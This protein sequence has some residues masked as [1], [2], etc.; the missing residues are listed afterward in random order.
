[1]QKYGIYSGIS[2]NDY[3]GNKDYVSS[4]Q[5]KL[6]S[7]NMAMY[8]AVVLEGFSRYDSEALSFGRK[9]HSF[10]LEPKV[11]EKEYAIM[12]EKIDMRTKAGKVTMEQFKEIN[13]NK[14]VVRVDEMDTLN[15]MRE[16]LITYDPAATLLLKGEA[17]VSCYYKDERTGMDLQTRP[18]WINHDKKYLV[19][20]KTVRD[21]S[22]FQRDMYKYG[23]DLS[24]ALYVDSLKALTASDYDYYFV[25]VEKD[26][27]YSVAVYRVSER[28]L[29]AGR[30]KYEV[31]LDNILN[32]KETNNYKFQ[33]IIEEL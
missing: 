20:L 15:Y 25:A 31:A 1:M 16:A 7:K 10:L 4:S 28:T 26:T 8:K 14:E 11:F 3:H 22:D 24:A 17:E 23:Y 12:T 27:P 21:I 30:K 6:A 19:D 18:D 5:I 33:N 32:A 2:N 9:A 13:G 29:N